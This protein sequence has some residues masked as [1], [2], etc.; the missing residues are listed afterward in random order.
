M[1]R[2]VIFGALDAAVDGVDVDEPGGWRS[3]I[4]NAI[5]ANE[6]ITVDAIEVNVNGETISGGIEGN[7]PESEPRPTVVD[8]SVTVSATLVI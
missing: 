5:E 1:S 3:V 4:E 2:E 6:V 7:A 8:D